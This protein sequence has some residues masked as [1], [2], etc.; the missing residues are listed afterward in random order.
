M[1]ESMEGLSVTLAAAPELRT[2]AGRLTATMRR[3][4]FAVELGGTGQGAASDAVRDLAAGETRLALVP[5]ESPP[6]LPE[7]VTWAAVPVRAEPRDV[8]VAPGAHSATL[9]S[10]APG[11]RVGVAGARR[12]SFLHAHRPDVE[13]VALA[14]GGGA[15]PAL[16]SGSIDAAILGAAEARRGDAALRATELLDPK[17]WIPGP[18]QGALLLLARRDDDDAHRAASSLEHAATR[19]ALTAE[20]TVMD[21]LGVHP[22]A[23]LGVLALPH[24]RWI[25]LWAMAASDDGRDVVRG[26]LTGALDQPEAVGRALADL[27][28]VRGALTILRGRSP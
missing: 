2:E 28:C 23:P 4:G 7:G 3:R 15:G 27:L 6:E 11:S 12:R 22:G 5:A 19:A 21:A 20:A 17:A 8:L 1:A 26:D 14:D 9:R 24:G 10:L 25:R 18:R 16:A 13:A